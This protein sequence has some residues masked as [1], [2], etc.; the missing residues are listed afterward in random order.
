MYDKELRA[1]LKRQ[2]GYT[3]ELI[4]INLDL[5]E[6][7]SDATG[8]YGNLDSFSL[9]YNKLERLQAAIDNNEN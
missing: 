8:R 2:V 3:Q 5:L 7:L 9:I 4:K 6:C 1:R